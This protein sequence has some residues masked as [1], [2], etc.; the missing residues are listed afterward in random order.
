MAALLERRVGDVSEGARS[1]EG[2]RRLGRRESSRRRKGGKTGKRWWRGWWRG[3]WRRRS[4][5][6]EVGSGEE[7]VDGS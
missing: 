6:D 5:R 4:G 1:G 7:D 3:W 2:R